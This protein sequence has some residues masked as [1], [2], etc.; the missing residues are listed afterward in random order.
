MRGVCFAVAL[1]GAGREEWKWDAEG[2][3]GDE[4]TGRLGGGGGAAGRAWALPEKKPAPPPPFPEAKPTMSIE[5]KPLG[6][7]APGAFYMTYRLSSA[8]MGFFD[9][10]HLLFT[11]RMGGLLKRSPGDSPG[12]DDQDIRA[13]VL[14]LKTG[15]RPSRRNGGCTIARS[16]CGRI[17]MG[18]FW[19]GCGIRCSPRTRSCSWNRT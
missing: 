3:G 4:E 11:F 8:A 9:D 10:D 1:E 2:A 5:G 6:Y 13:L 7:R 17:R 18:S 12:D 15:R 14:D 19:C 16:I